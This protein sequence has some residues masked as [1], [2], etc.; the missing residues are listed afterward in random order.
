MPVIV[1]RCRTDS[2]ARAHRPRTA[3]SQTENE[4]LP[5]VRVCSIAS[6]HDAYE[7]QWTARHARWPIRSRMRLVT[8]T[9]ATRS[10]ETTP[11]ATGSDR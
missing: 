5:A 6:G 7:A 1:V 4:S 2:R 11:K 8:I 9:A 3:S 10:T